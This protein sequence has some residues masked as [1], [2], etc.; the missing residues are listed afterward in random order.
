MSKLR[1]PRF[2]LLD[3]N[4]T[5][6]DK[7]IQGSRL[8]TIRQVLLCFL[9]H[10]ASKKKRD[11]ANDTVKAVLPLYQKARIEPKKNRCRI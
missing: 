5:E 4:P 3:T 2:F 7:Q 9:S 6:A 1:D 11:A 10:H 8:P